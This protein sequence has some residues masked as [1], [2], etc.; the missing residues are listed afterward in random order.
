MLFL[1]KSYT[2]NVFFLD[3]GETRRDGRARVL[4]TGD[5][6]SVVFAFAGIENRDAGRNK[7]WFL[8]EV[9]FALENRVC[10]LLLPSKKTLR[11]S[12][13]YV[14]V[15]FFPFSCQVSSVSYGTT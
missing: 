7:L 6:D 10:G 2:Y 14:L 11:R 12:Y 13:R 4:K 1:Q 15:W 3:T 9:N 8:A 5:D